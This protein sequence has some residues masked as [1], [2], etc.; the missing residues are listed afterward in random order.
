MEV[1]EFGRF[2]DGGRSQGT[3]LGAEPLRG[4]AKDRSGEALVGLGPGPRSC[5]VESWGRLGPLQQT[6]MDVSRPISSR[7]RRLGAGHRARRNWAKRRNR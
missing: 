4:S 3:N 5:F 7:A 6:S 1:V 2:W